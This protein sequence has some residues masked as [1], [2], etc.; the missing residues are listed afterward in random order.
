MIFK[1]NDEQ[2]E[3]LE[4]WIINH[5]ESCTYFKNPGAIGG[6]LDYIFTPNSIGESLVVKCI[7]E[8]EIDLTDMGNW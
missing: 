6:L 1:I 3:K 2:S 8:E 7:C 4:D 5:K